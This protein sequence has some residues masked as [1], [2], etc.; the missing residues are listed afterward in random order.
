[1]ENIQSN[2]QVN[3]PDVFEVNGQ[4]VSLEE[5]RSGYMR[6][7]DYTKK[8]QEL[9][10]E[11]RRLAERPQDQETD[12]EMLKA[13]EILKSHGVV[14]RDELA[15]Q[16]QAKDQQ[17]QLE[18]FISLNPSFANHKKTLEI[19][20]KTDN[21]DFA[22]IAVDYNLIPREQIEEAKTSRFSNNSN[23]INAPQN[24]VS[25]LNLSPKEWEQW[26]ANNARGD[27]Y[28]RAS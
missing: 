21:R 15:E 17:K 6:H 24:E 22:D 1:M 20:R 23:F 14:T 9:A 27:M 11:K 25:L 10:E 3:T 2:D 7:S 13:V 5:L 16:M 4:Q 19:L 18:D 26:K 12:L 28:K 8:T